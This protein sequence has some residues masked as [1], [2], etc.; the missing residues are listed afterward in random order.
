MSNNIK[1]YLNS[2]GYIRFSYN[3]CRYFLHRY[4]MKATKNQIIDHK[5]GN[6]LN[7]KLSN[8]RF[9]TYSQN[10]ANIVKNKGISKYK[11]VSF[12]KNGKRIKRWMARCEIKGRNITIG[13]FLT[14]KEAAIAYN[15]KAYELWG[16][17]AVLNKVN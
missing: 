10:S 4:V 14:E 7:N 13:R 5:N 9:C 6:K 16:E 12:D 17:F 3:K 8:L 1:L 15:I 2:C 11:G